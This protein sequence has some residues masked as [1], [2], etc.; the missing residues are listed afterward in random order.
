MVSACLKLTAAAA[1][2]FALPLGFAQESFSTEK[3]SQTPNDHVL[4]K[5]ANCLQGDNVVSNYG[6]TTATTI[7]PLLD[8]RKVPIDQ[9][10][11]A[12]INGL[13]QVIVS[14]AGTGY[15][16]YGYLDYTGYNGDNIPASTAEISSF[17]F[18]IKADVTS[19]IY[20]A[21]V[22]NNR[23][24]KVTV[25]TGIITTIAGTGDSGYNADG[26]PATTAWLN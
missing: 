13:D 12:L 16:S 5:L 23:V 2:V 3:T 17:T 21:E 6:N 9:S 7:A 10:E 1:F 11:R 20:F 26:I 19:D 15:D 8:I 25:S 24:R 4:H 18:G 14:I 22:V